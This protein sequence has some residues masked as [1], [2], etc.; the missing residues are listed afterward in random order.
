MC[1]DTIKPYSIR[2]RVNVRSTL[3]VRNDIAAD[4]QHK[5]LRAANSCPSFLEVFCRKMTKEKYL[6][7]KKLIIADINQCV[8][9][10][11]KLSGKTLLICFEGNYIE[12]TFLLILRQEHPVEIY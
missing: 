1:G 10:Y 3:G 11:S 8:S 5:T 7:Q 6:E 12:V 9:L 2:K 4:G